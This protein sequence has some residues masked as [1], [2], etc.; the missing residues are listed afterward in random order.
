MT[1]DRRERAAVHA[2]AFRALHVPAAPLVLFNVWDAASA[3]VVASQGAKALAT[4]SA[5]VGVAHGFGD[6]EG[7]PLWLAAQNVERI[8]ARHDLPLTVDIE[9]GYG[10]SPRNV[11]D[12]VMLILGA[13][14]CGF[15][16]EDQVIGK[17][18]LFS[19]EEQASRIAAA[20]DGAQ[21]AGVEAFINARTDVFL[22]NPA[23]EHGRLVDDVVA[24]GRAYREAGADGLFVP[25]LTSIDL[26]GRLCRELPIPINV[27]ILPNLP[28]RAELAR[29]GVARISYGF[30]PMQGMMR[31]LT[32]AAREALQSQQ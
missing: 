28:E 21:A 23:A 9:S 25:G 10:L 14:A 6:G 32:T 5:A 29:A 30:A 8:S 17:K 4:S 19:I 18:S 31:A 11:T 7:L 26:I 16:I 20:R 1:V 24:R 3:M 22:Q 15:N 27:M 12:T 2:R 13:G